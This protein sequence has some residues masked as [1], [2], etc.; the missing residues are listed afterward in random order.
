MNR[1]YN[2]IKHFADSNKVIINNIHRPGC[3]GDQTWPYVHEKHH[4]KQLD[5][6][7]HH[8]GFE[9]YEYDL[10]MSAGRTDTPSW[11]QITIDR[12]TSSFYFPQDL[13][14][15]EHDHARRQDIHHHGRS[16]TC[17]SQRHPAKTHSRHQ[18]GN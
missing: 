9:Y 18:P 4:A 14:D 6:K 12:C 3:V 16:E 10:P 13:E 7:Q 17:W 11:A 2:H 5:D 8:A 15:L 1:S